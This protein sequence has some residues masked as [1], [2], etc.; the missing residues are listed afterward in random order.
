[1]GTGAGN[2]NNCYVLRWLRCASRCVGRS[3][4]NGGVGDNQLVGLAVGWNIDRYG[5]SDSGSR[6][7]L[8]DLVVALALTLAVP[9]TVVAARATE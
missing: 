8:A 2:S 1:M 6:A 4:A 3:R 9:L 7:K 5:L